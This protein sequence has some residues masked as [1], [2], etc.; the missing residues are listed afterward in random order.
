[1]LTVYLNQIS[2][3][4]RWIVK[5]RIHRHRDGAE[6]GSPELQVLT[7]TVDVR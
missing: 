4:R 3:K 6:P 5:D 2:R 7:R 1:M